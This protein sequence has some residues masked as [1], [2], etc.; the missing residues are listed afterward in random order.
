MV[1]A[2]TRN[3]SKQHRAES[4]CVRFPE[5][6]S[7]RAVRNYQEATEAI[8]AAGSSADAMGKAIKCFEHATATMDTV[9]GWDAE[10]F[11]MQVAYCYYSFL[12]LYHLVMSDISQ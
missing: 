1:I 6:S 2:G 10:T 4:S 8:D 12:S 5:F 11:A 7:G 9:G 3:G